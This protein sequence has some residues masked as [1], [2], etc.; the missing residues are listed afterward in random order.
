MK[1]LQ[2][3]VTITIAYAAMLFSR[4]ST[5]AAVDHQIRLPNIVLVYADDLGWGDVHANNPDGCKIPTPHMDRVAA[6]GLTLTDVHSASGVCSP[7]R[8]SLLTGRY[9][10][11]SSLQRSIAYPNMDY[12]IDPKRLTLPEML[13]KQG[14]Y[15]GAIGKWHLDS[16]YEHAADEQWPAG[17]TDGGRRIAKGPL[18]HGFD[19]YYGTY[20]NGQDI[21][22]ENDRE[23]F[24]VSKLEDV[25]PLHTRK[26]VEFI[27]KHGGTEIENRRVPLF[28]YFALISPHDPLVPTDEWKGKTGMGDYADFVA[29]SDHAVG[30]LLAALSRVGIEDETIF[31]VTS[32]NGAPGIFAK[33]LKARYGHTSSGPFRGYKGDIWEGGHRVACFIKWP[34]V[35]DPGRT[36]DALVCQTDFFA[37]FADMAS[38]Q[39]ADA[40]AEDSISFLHLLKGADSGLRTDLVSHSFNGRFAIRK[41]KWKLIFG[42]GSGAWTN[43]QDREAA[44]KGMPPVQLYNLG[45]DPSE[46]TNLQAKYPNVVWHLSTLLEEQIDRGRSTPGNEQS[47]DVAIDYRKISEDHPDLD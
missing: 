41:G 7:S 35:I 23:V 45:T 15:S 14:Y 31:I 37:T 1:A 16:E 47:N 29:Q 8:Y 46:T 44:S 11:R 19:Y 12:L 6:E 30:E 26:A 3:R 22:I 38:I 13:N 17:P 9:C 33:P 32:D 40:T 24:K 21:M 25:L 20:T 34:G 4:M 2:P 18:S 42:A 28:L 10:W 36:S 27:E 43:P 39:C 5:Y